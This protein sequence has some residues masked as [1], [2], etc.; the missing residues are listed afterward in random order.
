MN[1]EDRQ[2]Y[3]GAADDLRLA[4]EWLAQAR[5]KLPST[6]TE[7]GA[8]GE[9]IDREKGGSPARAPIGSRSRARS[10]SL[11]FDHPPR[12]RSARRQGPGETMASTRRC[13][14]PSCSRI[15][16]RTMSSASTS[17]A[18]FRNGGRHHLGMAGGITRNQHLRLP[19]RTFLSCL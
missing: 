4:D 3:S 6:R 19:L 10:S 9:L 18:T 5:T 1:G 12:R 7:I 8:G 2:R 13:R 17:T 16:R 14:M 11:I 15:T